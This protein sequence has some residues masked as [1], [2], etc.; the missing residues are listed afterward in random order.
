M[1]ATSGVKFEQ[2]QVALAR[3]WMGDQADQTGGVDPIKEVFVKVSAPTPE[4]LVET[5][6]ATEVK[7]MR[8]PLP[9]S[10]EE[11]RETVAKFESG[12]NQLRGDDSVSDSVAQHKCNDH[13]TL[14]DEKWL[15]T[16]EEEK[17]AY[18]SE[19]CYIHTKCM[20]VD[21]RKVI[22]GSANLNDRSQKGDGDSEIA[23]VVEDG[24]MI[25]SRMDGV[26]YQA[27]R[28]AATLRR[29][30]F[31]EHLGLLGP[32][33]CEGAREHVTSFMRCA[34][35]PNHDETDTREDQWV[36]DPLGDDFQARWNDTARV[37]REVFTELFR[38]V[39]SN[40]V[41]SW[42]AYD[43]YVPKVKTGHVVP[44]IPLARVKD[45][46]AHV[47]GALVECPLDFLI[48]EKDFCEGLDW[49]GLNPTLA[50]YL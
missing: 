6:K 18:V 44:E 37:N 27:S 33:P 50:V 14:A 25:D 1:E 26:D 17:N 47:K 11:A 29:R 32:Q 10:A 36:M 8:V 45:R 22:M 9:Q 12:A 24:D 41:R 35:T 38:P 4:G 2:V 20:I 34:P 42:S 5:G 3:Q 31:K 16:E 15:G 21:D 46:L 48:D 40:L 19:L 23:M 43:N 39:P 49:Q 30:L 13:T 7:P 28:F